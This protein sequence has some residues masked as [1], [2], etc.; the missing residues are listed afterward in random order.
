MNTSFLKHIS[1]IPIEDA[2]WWSGSR[3]LLLSRQDAISN[4]VEAMTKGFLPIW[5]V[6]DW[7]SHTDIDEIF[8][9]LHGVWYVEFEDA[10]R[11]EYKKD[12]ILYIQKNTLHRVVNTWND[13]NIF[14]FIRIQNP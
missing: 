8:I 11:L 1:E 9:I 5:W 3:Q 6:F 7:H 14:Y 10:P 13:E 4:N 2:H 12:D